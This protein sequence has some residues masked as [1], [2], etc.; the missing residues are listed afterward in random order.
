MIL[1]S[2]NILPMFYPLFIL[3]G[4][5]FLLGLALAISSKYLKVKEDERIEE[6]KKRL[7]NVN[8]GACGYAGCDAFANAVIKGE[9]K[10]LSKCRAGDR[11][12]H[13][14]EI[15]EYLDKHPNK[16]GSKI[17]VTY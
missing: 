10:D 6:V 15:K 3:L 14:K 8:C 17:E 11:E 16:D 7:P 2:K 12:K 13:Y 5:G 9:I 4:L 1:L